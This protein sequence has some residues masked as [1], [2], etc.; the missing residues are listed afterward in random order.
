[1]DM[2]RMGGRPIERHRGKSDEE[3]PGAHDEALARIAQ[4]TA[5]RDRGSC[6]GRNTRGTYRVH[7]SVALQRGDGGREFFILACSGLWLGHHNDG[8]ART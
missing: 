1:M 8:P 7:G 2:E 3:P 4:H 5:P 6:L